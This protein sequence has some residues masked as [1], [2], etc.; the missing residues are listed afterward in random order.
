MI[1]RHPALLVLSLAVLSG[2]ALAQAQAPNQAIWKWRDANG[3]VQFSDQ[4]PPHSVPDKDIMS[5]PV[6]QRV[7]VTVLADAS[8]SAP[9]AGGSA[10]ARADAELEARKKKL[11]ADKAAADADR[12]QADKARVDALKADNCKR[13][14]AQLAMLESGVRVARPNDKGER[15]FLDDKARAEEV[16]RSRAAVTA[17]C[18]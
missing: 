1:R 7:P 18:Q 9:E 12:K 16:N 2:S 5:R 10:P 8:A 4:P 14:K 15:E 13:A 6:P 3:I 11:Q 17:N